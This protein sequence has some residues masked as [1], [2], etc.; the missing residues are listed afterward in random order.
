MSDIVLGLESSNKV[1]SAEL[2]TS[3]FNPR[4]IFSITVLSNNFW[5]VSNLLSLSSLPTWWR[6]RL[7]NWDTF[8]RSCTY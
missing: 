1:F 8:A 4:D 6:R 2:E 3:I 7:Q 5:K